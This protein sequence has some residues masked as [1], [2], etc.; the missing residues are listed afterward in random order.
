MA[1]ET[2]RISWWKDF[3]WH[4]TH[5]KV[6]QTGTIIRFDLSLIHDL[7]RW[8]LYAAIERS[9]NLFKTNKITTYATPKPPRYWYLLSVTLSRLGVKYVSHP[10]EAKLAL[11]FVD[12]TYIENDNAPAIANDAKRI[13]FDCLDI[14]KSQ[15]QSTFY[16]VFGYELKVDP[17]NY[18]GPIVVKTELNGAHSG[19]ILHGPV[20]AETGYVYQK[21]IDNRSK[22]GVTDLRCPTVFGQIPFIYLKSRPE[23]YRFDNFNSHVDLVPPDGFLSP[24]ELRLISQFCA[25]MKLDWGGLDILRHRHDGK[26]YIVDVN[27]TDM[28]PPLSLPLLKKLKSTTLLAKALKTGLEIK[29]Q[30]KTEPN[31][32]KLIQS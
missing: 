7:V 31:I 24:E 18:D 28:G 19:K 16:E 20:E 22:Y 2:K 23:S 6:K 5:V 29:C 15:V 14:S 21:L 32:T 25:K 1:I 26:I 3:E 10:D 11:H 27:K 4:L 13:N 12:D 8:L 30:P 17:Q 9:R